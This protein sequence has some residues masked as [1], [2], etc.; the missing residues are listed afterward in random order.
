MGA[1]RV[2]ALLHDEGNGM[3][4]LHTQIRHVQETK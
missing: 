2:L 4:M 3:G 1:G